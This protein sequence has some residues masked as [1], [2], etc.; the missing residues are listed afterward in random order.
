MLLNDDAKASYYQCVCTIYK[1]NI[2][3]YENGITY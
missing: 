3:E 1:S 2:I